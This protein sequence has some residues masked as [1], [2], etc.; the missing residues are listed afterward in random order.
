M[1]CSCCNASASNIF[2]ASTWVSTSSEYAAPHPKHLLLRYP[3]TAWSSLLR[4]QMSRFAIN[5]YRVTDSISIISIQ[6]VRPSQ[7]GASPRPVKI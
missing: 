7:R 1:A 4:P 6:G 2:T 5:C 3:P